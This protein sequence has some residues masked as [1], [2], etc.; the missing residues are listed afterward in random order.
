LSRGTF[1]GG[2]PSQKAWFTGTIRGNE[3]TQGTPPSLR[4][5]KKVGALEKGKALVGVKN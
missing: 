2:K 1:R 5:G 4:K 3:H